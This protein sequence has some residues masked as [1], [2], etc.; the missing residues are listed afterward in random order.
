MSYFNIKFQEILSFIVGTNNLNQNIFISLLFSFYTDRN[1]WCT[2][3]SRW[4]K[5]VEY[6]KGMISRN[7]EEWTCNFTH[8]SKSNKHKARLLSL[9]YVIISIR[10]SGIRRK[11]FQRTLSTKLKF[12]KQDP[13]YIHFS[14]SP[15]RSSKVLGN[16][17]LQPI[18][19]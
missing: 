18:Q 10:D 5:G 19:S 8:F 17:S 15:S 7:L 2:F 14:G 13:C 9:I 1:A 3:D 16:S 12:Y 4:L 6:Y 11:D